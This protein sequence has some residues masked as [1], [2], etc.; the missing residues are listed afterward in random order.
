M[1]FDLVDL[2][3]FLNAIETGSLTAAAANNNVVV[4]AA[5]ARLRRIEDAFKVRLFA[6]TNRGVKPT[7]AGEV[8][9]GH[10]RKILH[11]AR[12]LEMELDEFAEGKSGLVRLLSNTNMLAEHLPQ[13]LGTFL[14]ANPDISVDVQEI[15]SHEV[16][17]L[18]AEGEADIGIVASSADMV[19]LERS[20][21][22]TDSLVAVVPSDSVLDPVPTEFSRILDFKLI[23]TK[24]NTALQQFLH[25]ITNQMGRKMDVRMQL[26]NFE[27]IC[28]M[29]SCKTGVAIVPESAALRY[30]ATMDFRIVPL[31]DPWAVRELYLCVKSEREMPSFG[32][33]L[34][35]H[36]Q[37]YVTEQEAARTALRG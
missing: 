2:T 1:R 16:V 25:R 30:A 21:F 32:R 15:P 13:A 29:V 12:R 36:L 26:P 35:H 28:R 19:G 20:R 23:G 34:L 4:A 17:R 3:I 9:A 33:K 5:S 31:V 11:L 7:L 24:D 6:R 37:Q 14:A 8:F 27:G 18:V 22:V 10:A